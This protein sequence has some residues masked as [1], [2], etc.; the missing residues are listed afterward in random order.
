[1]INRGRAGYVR[2]PDQFQFLPGAIQG[3]RL[4]A[5]RGWQLVSVTNQDAAGWKLLPEAQLAKVHDRMLAGR[6]K[7]RVQVA[8]IYY[9][10]HNVLSDRAC[11]KPPPGR[12][13]AA[14]RDVGA[15]PRAAGRVGHE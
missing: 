12:S 6:R 11:R 7:A 15:R 10:P 4:L 5:D 2:R 14:A 3:M 1:M 9:C 13:L 8:E